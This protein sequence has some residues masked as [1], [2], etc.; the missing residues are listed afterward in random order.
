MGKITG[1]LEYQREIPT[2]R[3]PSKRI[4]DWKEFHEP[5]AEE[6]LQTQGARCMD[7]GVPFCHTGALLSGMA[8]G[9]PINNLIPD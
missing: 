2:D 7:C 8:T 5:M 3:S 6:K 1:F 9:C 4:K